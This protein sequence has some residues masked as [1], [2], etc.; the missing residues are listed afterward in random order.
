MSDSVKFIFKSLIKVPI[1]IFIAF[2]IINLFSFFF[3]YFKML[4]ISYVVM[5]TTVENNFLP[6]TETDALLNYMET[7]SRISC[8]ND[9][10]IVIKDETGN[11]AEYITG[12]T[13][14][15]VYREDGTKIVSNYQSYG[16][17]ALKR[18]Q[19]GSSQTVGVYCEFTIMWPL[20]QAETINGGEV[21]GY[22]GT[23]PGTGRV[24]GGAELE[25]KREDDKHK[26]KI[27]IKITYT[28]PGLKYYPDMT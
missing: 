6:T 17:G 19:Y 24:L 14:H 22:D 10:G 25:Q 27:P 26:V 15:A 7:V 9:A 20:T 2:F 11:S 16:T 1:I 28:I 21:I 8:V 4:G 13:G 3:L 12:K 18:Q 5:E 23:A